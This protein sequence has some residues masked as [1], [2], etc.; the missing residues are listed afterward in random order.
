MIEKME[1]LKSFETEKYKHIDIDR[2]VMY[3]A[4]ELDKLKIELSLE[5][6]VVGAFKLFPKKFSLPGYPEYPDAIRVD[7]ALRRRHKG[8]WIGG[9]TAHGFW[10]TDMTCE[11]AVQTEALLKGKSLKK[12]RPPSKMQRRE[13]ILRDVERSP[14]YKKYLDGNKESITEADLCY[15][16][17]GTLD[18]ATETLRTNF[19]A[20]LVYAEQLER[21]DLIEFFGW[22]KET[23]GDYLGL[24]N[25]K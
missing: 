10:V 3:T 16:L 25:L 2:L 24:K 11:V 19:S 9:K 13:S 14:G 22:I 23:F 6:I 20:I 18:S 5:N 21:K 15:L 1:K 4:V 7:K 8:R 12:T 17:Q